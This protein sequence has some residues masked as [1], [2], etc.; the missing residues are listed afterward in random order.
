MIKYIIS[1]LLLFCP[2]STKSQSAEIYYDLVP[3]L[4]KTKFLC[5]TSGLKAETSHWGNKYSLKFNC[6][7]T[8][9]YVEVYNKQNV[10]IAQGQYK[11][12]SVDTINTMEI[13]TSKGIVREKY[14]GIRH[15]FYKEGVWFSMI[16]RTLT[17]EYYKKG[18]KILHSIPK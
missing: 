16:R 13:I 11:K 4:T 12:Y 8:V 9:I 7:S 17:I 5:S 18:I 6:D 14:A 3:C 1:Y 10:C 15:K 2:G